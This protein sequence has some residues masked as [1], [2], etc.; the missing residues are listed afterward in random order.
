MSDFWSEWII[1]LTVTSLFT[2]YGLVWWGA[3][4]S[5]DNVSEDKLRPGYN[6]YSIPHTWLYLFYLSLLF[7]VVYFSLYP[8]LGKFTGV[9]KWT[10]Q[11]QYDQERKQYNAQYADK[12]NQYLSRPITEVAKDQAAQQ[13]GKRLF[14]A[15]CSNCHQ[16][17]KEE[18]NLHYP[19]LSDKDWLWGGEPERIK[20]TIIKGRTGIMPAWGAILGEK[21]ISEI[22]NYVMTL[23]NRKPR[24]QE[25]VTV[26]H[27]KFVIY[28][29]LCH[30][31][32]G[33]G[34]PRVGVPNLTD[35]IWLHIASREVAT[36]ARLEAGI[37]QAIANGF[38]NSMPPHWKMLDQARIHLL[39]SYVYGLSN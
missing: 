10:S 29:Q 19:N 30:G 38:V 15:Y 39:A 32:D 13:I 26:G 14:L 24:D 21:E 33:K 17:S 18:E 9:S 12:F 23:S 22:A 6:D 28:C 35:Q 34:D 8:G 4:R 5:T 20:E 37:K 36:D 11:G 7:F 1:V 16:V 3:K 25:K 2:G 27:E 31:A